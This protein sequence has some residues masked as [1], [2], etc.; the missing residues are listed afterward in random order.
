MAL[1]AYKTSLVISS[2]LCG[3]GFFL[4]FYELGLGKLT[5]LDC[6]RL[7][8]G[9]GEVGEWRQFLFAFLS[10]DD[11]LIMSMRLAI[12]L[13]MVLDGLRGAYRWT[14]SSKPDYTFS[15][16]TR[17]DVILLAVVVV[18]VILGIRNMSGS[19]GVG[20]WLWIGSG[21]LTSVVAY[22]NQRY[23]EGHSGADRRQESVP[24][25]L[26]PSESFWDRAA[27]RAVIDQGQA[28]AQVF[29]VDGCLECGNCRKSVLPGEGLCSHCGAELSWERRQ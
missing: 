25:D 3:I 7:L 23:F 8:F 12:P 4:P 13:G 21:L 5:G 1:T 14:R 19:L 9:V 16:S 11:R 17:G 26:S 2:A 27:R 10:E 18:L 15:L 28:R 24:S 6:V 20:A 29:N 22:A